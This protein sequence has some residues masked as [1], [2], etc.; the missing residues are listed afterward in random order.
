[1][2]AENNFKNIWQRQTAAPAPAATVITQKARQYQKAI[3]NKLL[4]GIL[5]LLATLPVIIFIVYVAQPQRLT[6]II[7]I[8]LA[9]IAIVSYIAV[10]GNLLRLVY[11]RQPDGLPVKQQLEQMVRI[12]YQQSF[13]QKQVLTAYFI[14]LSTG[15][16]LYMIEYALHY[17]LTGQLLA[18]GITSL[19]LA[20]NWFYIRPKTIHKQ[21]AG[22]NE[23]ISQLELVRH[24]LEE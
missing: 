2:S 6:T 21:Q 10:A 7:G 23:I 20:F 3:R 24:Q 4:L 17:N 13:L 18:Y 9:C 15:I 11:R 16:F 1:M 22:L 19:W 12:R 8:V 14:L 5:L